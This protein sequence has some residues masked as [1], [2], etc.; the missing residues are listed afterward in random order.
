MDE[1]PEGRRKFSRGR[2]LVESLCPT[3]V[4]AGILALAASVASQHRVLALSAIFLLLLIQS[5]HA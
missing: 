5:L 2:L 3:L 4:T 1:R